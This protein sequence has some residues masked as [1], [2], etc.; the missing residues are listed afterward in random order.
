MHTAHCTLHH[1][2]PQCVHSVGILRSGYVSPM[3]TE[4]GHAIARPTPLPG[5]ASRAGGDSTRAPRSAH[6]AVSVM[7]T[8]H[9]LP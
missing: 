4:T 8:R 6:G 7:P 9:H 5:R 2:A 1:N 3:Y